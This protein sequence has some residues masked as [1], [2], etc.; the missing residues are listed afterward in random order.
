MTPGRII[1][2]PGCHPAI[3]TLVQQKDPLLINAVVFYGQINRESELR[4]GI[5]EGQWHWPER[6]EE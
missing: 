2:L 3:V 1:H 6:E 4:I 5:P